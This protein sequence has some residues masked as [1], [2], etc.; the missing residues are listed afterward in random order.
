MNTWKCGEWHQ[1]RPWPVCAPFPYSASASL[2][3][4]CSW[5]IPFYKKSS[6]DLF[7]WV[8]WTALSSSSTLRG[9][10]GNLQFTVGLS[11]AQ[12]E[13]QRQTATCRGG[14][15]C[16]WV[17]VKVAQL[18]PTLCDP[19]DYTVHGILQARMLDWVAFPSS[20][21]SSQ[22][23]DGTQVSHIASGFFTSWAI[24]EALSHCF[25]AFSSSR[26]SSALQDE[27][28]CPLLKTF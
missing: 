18:C 17:W 22:P 13:E 9:A 2:L 8:L 3:P 5:T 25:P 11:E 7:S 27:F 4:G 21:G 23:R 26:G 10:R 12:L 6:K 15:V 20:R 28:Y 24:R 19:M 1:E 16:R 14:T